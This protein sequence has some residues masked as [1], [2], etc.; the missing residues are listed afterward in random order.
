MGR[1]I[2][3]ASQGGTRR[4]LVLI[5]LLSLFAIAQGSLQTQCPSGP[6]DDIWMLKDRTERQRVPIQRLRASSTAAS[7]LRGQSPNSEAGTDP[8]QAIR[9]RQ[10][11]GP[12]VHAPQAARSHS[13]SITK[14]GPSSPCQAGSLKPG[15]SPV[16][17]CAQVPDTSLTTGS[18]GT[19]PSLVCMHMSMHHNG[20]FGS[21]SEPTSSVRH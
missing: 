4:Q 15:S 13:P 19:C 9:E 11:P 1:S 21:S 2:G 5:L 7:S 3:P 10:V 20:H 12:R 16:S 6:T 18:A 8:Q 14:K 17:E